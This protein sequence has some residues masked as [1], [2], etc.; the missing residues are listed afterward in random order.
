MQRPPLRHGHSKLLVVEVVTDSAAVVVTLVVVIGR[1]LL[2]IIVV[3]AP[4]VDCV[5]GF[6]VTSKVEV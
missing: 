4:G 1:T 2:E 5:K 6:V 3:V